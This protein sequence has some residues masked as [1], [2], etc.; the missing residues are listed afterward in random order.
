MV[1]V[2]DGAYAAVELAERCIDQ[3]A[4]PVSRL[5]LDA[6]LFAQTRNRKVNEVENRKRA[7]VYQS[8]A[9]WSRTQPKHG[10]WLK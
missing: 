6:R 4:T 5:R 10:D 3:G 1:L 9:N 7:S 8:L 2:G